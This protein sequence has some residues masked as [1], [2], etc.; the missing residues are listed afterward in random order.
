M[1]HGLRMWCDYLRCLYFFLKIEVDMCFKFDLREVLDIRDFLKKTTSA[2]KLRFDCNFKL[3]IR[4]SFEIS[5]VLI[6][7]PHTEKA[8]NYWSCKMNLYLKTLFS[9]FSLIDFSVNIWDALMSLLPVSFE[10]IHVFWEHP[11][12]HSDFYLNFRK[13]FYLRWHLISYAWK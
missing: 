4:I 13:S 9:N 8:C 10:H 2:F 7:M 5:D 1:H 3:W 11:G 6:I 12:G